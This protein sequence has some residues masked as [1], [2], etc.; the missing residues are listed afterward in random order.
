MSIAS[1]EKPAELPVELPQQD[2]GIGRR[3]VL[4]LVVAGIAT[5]LLHAV[6]PLVAAPDL[7]GVGTWRGVPAG[8][9]SFLLIGGLFFLVRG[10]C[11]RARNRNPSERRVGIRGDRI[12]LW[13]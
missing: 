12:D 6:A 10:S 7:W 9:R 4:A 2:R 11:E 13:S 3:V 5:L 8:W 1:E